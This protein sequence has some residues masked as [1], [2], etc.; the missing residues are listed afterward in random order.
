MVCIYIWCN[1]ER[2]IERGGAKSE[3]D[4]NIQILTI[5]SSVHGKKRQ[6]EWEKARRKYRKCAHVE[7][8]WR[9]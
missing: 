9:E 7:S 5:N 8:Q 3:W 1:R 4:A 2:E 6:C